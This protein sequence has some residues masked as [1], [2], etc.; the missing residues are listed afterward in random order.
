M[1]GASGE[2]P[3]IPIPVVSKGK[4]QCFSFVSVDMILLTGRVVSTVFKSSE[5]IAKDF[6]DVPSV[7]FA[8]VRA[9][10]KDS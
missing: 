7:L 8:Q 1:V 5:T 3:S 9:V 2:S 4:H 6:A 10:C